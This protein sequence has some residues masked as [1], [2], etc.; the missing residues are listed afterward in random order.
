MNPKSHTRVSISML[1][2]IGMI[3][4]FSYLLLKGEPSEFD[5]WLPIVVLITCPLMHVFMHRD[6]H[7]HKSNDQEE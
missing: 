6:H 4:V 7:K 1:T 2:C 3:A 5:A